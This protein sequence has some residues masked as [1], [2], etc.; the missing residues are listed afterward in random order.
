M[1][2][3]NFNI[4]KQLTM[5]KSSEISPTQ[6]TVEAWVQQYFE[7]TRSNNAVRW[8]SCFA[9][10]AIVEDPVGQPVIQSAAEILAQG[11]SFLANYQTVGLTETFVHIV[12]FQAVVKWVGKGIDL[13]GN[14]VTLE[15]IDLFEFN[16]NGEIVKLLGY[17]TPPTSD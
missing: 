10:N 13:D 7:S 6:S 5:S 9:K 17:W 12:G 16:K 4:F 11:E 8:A 2:K 1:I 3:L 14:D 15:G